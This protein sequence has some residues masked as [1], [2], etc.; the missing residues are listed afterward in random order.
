MLGGVGDNWFF[1]AMERRHLENREPCPLLPV[2]EEVLTAQVTA[3][4]KR[5]YNADFYRV[6]LRY[7]QS[8]WLEGKPAQALLQLNKAFMADLAGNETILLEWPLPYAA[9]R[10]VMVNCPAGEFL[11]NPVRHYQH[12]ATRMSGPRPELRRWRAWACFHLAEVVVG[13]EANPRDA[14]QLGREKIVIPDLGEV[15]AQLGDLGLC[16]EAQLVEEVIAG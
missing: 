7:A 14:G 13:G 4:F 11:G 10:W 16:G 6:S 15:L 12:L 3:E 8:L 9:K 2:V 5:D 1:E